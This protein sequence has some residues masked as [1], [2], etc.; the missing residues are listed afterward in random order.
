MRGW[1]SDEPRKIAEA[2]DL[3]VSRSGGRV[4]VWYA[5]LDRSVGRRRSLVRATTDNP[6]VP[7]RERQ[8]AGR[9]S[10]RALKEVT[11]NRSK[12]DLGFDRRG[13]SR[14]VSRQSVSRPMIGARARSATLKIMPL[15]GSKS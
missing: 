5:D 1:D 11:S 14:E 13:L 10:P 15:D 7:G 12:G 3:H 9:I 4:D 2:D 6:V 8:K